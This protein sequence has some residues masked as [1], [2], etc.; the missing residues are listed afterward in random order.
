MTKVKLTLSD[1]RRDPSY[2]TMAPLPF[3]QPLMP[4][5]SPVM[6][7][8]PFNSHFGSPVMGHGMPSLGTPFEHPAGLPPRPHFGQVHQLPHRPPAQAQSPSPLPGPTSATPVP[9]QAAGTP[10]DGDAATGPPS[11]MGSPATTSS[12]QLANATYVPHPGSFAPGSGQTLPATGGIVNM[13][14]PPSPPQPGVQR[15]TAP[16]AMHNRAATLPVSPPWAVSERLPGD[17]VNNGGPFGSKPRRNSK[18]SRR[19]KE[20]PGGIVSEDG[21]VIQH[22]P[23]QQ[24]KPAPKMGP[25][26]SSSSGLVDYCN[27]IVKVSLPPVWHLLIPRTWT[28]ILLDHTCSAS[29]RRTVTLSTLAS[30]ATAMA[31]H[32][33]LALSPSSSLLKVR[34]YPRM[35]R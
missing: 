15:F 9:Q 19:W 23:G 3:Q 25:G 12:Q 13:V 21:T 30:C 32:A 17:G 29:S 27:L 6:S 7:P 14:P 18:S 1:I 35:A 33:A 8:A 22:G 24:I 16:W 28:P 2:I 11:Q 5:G 4:L 20:V 34:G 26:S 31:G 10:L